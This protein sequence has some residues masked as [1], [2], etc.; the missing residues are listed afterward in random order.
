[1]GERNKVPLGTGYGLNDWIRVLKTQRSIS[2]RR[3]ITLADLAAHKVS[4]YLSLSI[5]LSIYIYIV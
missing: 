2:S 5:S 4:L 1:M 3:A